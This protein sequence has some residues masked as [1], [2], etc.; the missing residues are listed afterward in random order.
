M[1][2]RSAGWRPADPYADPALV[3]RCR[4]SG[5]SRTGKPGPAPPCAQS[6]VPGRPSLLLRPSGRPRIS[7]QSL[8]HP[9]LL[10]ALQAPFQKIDLQGLLAD[11]ALQLSDAA[12]RPALRS[13]A[14]KRVAW[15]TPELP[16]PAVQHVGI[17]LQRPRRFADGSP[18][19]QPP[20]RGQLEL[21]GEQPA[22]QP[23]DSIL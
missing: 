12:F 10:D 19:L 14:R 17:D 22:W 16:P 8:Q 3:R 18:L 5:R 4:R 6:S 11:L 23:H 21:F 1:P 9:L 7:S 20:H 13:V 2:A 15:P